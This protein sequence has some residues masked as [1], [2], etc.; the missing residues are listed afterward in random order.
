M[1]GNRMKLVLHI[2][3][4]DQARWLDILFEL[5]NGLQHVKKVIQATKN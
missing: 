2:K 1:D 4:V 5:T 3:G